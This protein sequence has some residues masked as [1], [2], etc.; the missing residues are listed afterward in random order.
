MI[1][2]PRLETVFDFPSEWAGGGGQGNQGELS[3]DLEICSYLQFYCPCRYF[4]VISLTTVVS[5]GGGGGELGGGLLLSC[6][7]I[8][9]V[10]LV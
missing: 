3:I 7:N 6:Q 1:F 4:A 9:S 2:S 5:F 10:G 8:S